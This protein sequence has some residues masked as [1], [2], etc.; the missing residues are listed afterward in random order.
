MLRF[1]TGG[2]P[3]TVKDRNA[4]AGIRRIRELGLAA[5]EL[6]FVYQIFLDKEKAEEVRKVAEELDVALSVHGSYY[7]NAE[8]ACEYYKG[9]TGSK[10]W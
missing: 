8:M 4:I 5:M 1:G 3:L 9:R 6:E 2:I 10:N 7:V